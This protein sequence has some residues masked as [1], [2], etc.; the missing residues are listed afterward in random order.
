MKHCEALNPNTV[1]ENLV[2]EKSV[3]LKK[4]NSQATDLLICKVGKEKKHAKMLVS[5]CR[6]CC[7]N[8]KQ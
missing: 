4:G 2:E 7:C 5:H 8:I 1:K 3:I 6:Y